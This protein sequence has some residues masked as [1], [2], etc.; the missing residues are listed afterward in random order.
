MVGRAVL[1]GSICLLIS[2]KP[3][4]HGRKGFC[5]VWCDAG[6]IPL[7]VEVSAPKYGVLD[8]LVMEPSGTIAIGKHGKLSRDRLGDSW[9]EYYSLDWR[10]S[11][12]LRDNVPNKRQMGRRR[13]VFASAVYAR[14]QQ[15]MIREGFPDFSGRAYAEEDFRRFLEGSADSLII[16]REFVRALQARSR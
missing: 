4:L 10:T 6:R 15:A 11:V 14:I 2:G 3:V 8:T 12:S 16:E 5:E 1:V 13:F 9:R 7:I